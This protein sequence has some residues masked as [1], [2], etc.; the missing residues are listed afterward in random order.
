MKLEG[1]TNAQ[2]VNIILRKDDVETRLRKEIATLKEENKR[3]G[4]V[5]LAKTA[6]VCLLFAVICIAFFTLASCDNSN[7]R[8]HREDCHDT[9]VAISGQLQEKERI[10]MQDWSFEVEYD[11]ISFFGNPI[12]M[13]DWT[14][15]LHQIRVIASEDDMLCYESGIHNRTLSV[16][17]VKF[18]VNIDGDG[19]ILVSST[20]V[21]APKMK[22]VVEYLKGI[23][24][25]PEEDEPDNYWWHVERDGGYHGKTVRMRP[26]HSEEGG[27]VL[28]FN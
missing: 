26:L 19:I 11:T 14:G 16:G 23:Y 20:E 10:T 25:A 8:T 5:C 12:V 17:K 15:I 22:Q 1:M 21:D 24:G 6:G 27:T 28:L 9:I 3:I 13:D 18:G 2:L 7:Q 4:R